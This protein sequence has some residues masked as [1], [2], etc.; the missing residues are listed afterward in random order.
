[1]A[2]LAAMAASLENGHA[3]NACFQQRIL[4]SIQL[5]WLENG[6]DL[7]HVQNASFD[8]VTGWTDGWAV[9]TGLFNKSFQT[10]VNKSDMNQERSLR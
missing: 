6:F 10:G 4:D 3:F 9:L 1:V 5:G 8:S 2:L 7:E